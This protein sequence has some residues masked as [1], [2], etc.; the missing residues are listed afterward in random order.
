MADPLKLQPPEI[1]SDAVMDAHDRGWRKFALVL[2]IIVCLTAGAV[3][4]HWWADW[5]EAYKTYGGFMIDI[6]MI[7]VIG[8]VGYKGIAG[9]M[10][11]KFAGSTTTTVTK[12]DPKKEENG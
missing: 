4:L 2:F 1:E 9:Y 6:L 11:G 5:E 3:T 8:N 12:I 10:N 7:Y